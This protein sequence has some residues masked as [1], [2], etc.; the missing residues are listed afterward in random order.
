M[1]AGMRLWV[2]WMAD[3]L[4]TVSE[5]PCETQTCSETLQNR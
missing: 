3:Q 2:P 1:L 4:H 5:N